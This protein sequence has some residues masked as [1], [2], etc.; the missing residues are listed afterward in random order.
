[1]F[2]AESRAELNVTVLTPFAFPGNKKDSILESYKVYVV[3]LYAWDFFFQEF[4][5]CESGLFHLHEEHRR[6]VYLYL[7]PF[8]V[9]T[10]DAIIS[11]WHSGQCFAISSSLGF[12]LYCNITSSIFM[13]YYRWP[14]IS[15]LHTGRTGLLSSI[16]SRYRYLIIAPPAVFIIGNFARHNNK[17]YE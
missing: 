11:D 15:V 10:T 5:M 6:S 1:M 2:Y 3:T 12:I 9:L 16:I 13:N 7:S 8:S 4:F 14:T 17:I